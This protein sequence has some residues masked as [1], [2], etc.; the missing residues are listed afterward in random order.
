MRKETYMKQLN[1]LSDEELA[2]YM[3]SILS[4]ET[5][6]KSRDDMD[7]DTFEVLNVAIKARG[8]REA[9]LG[10]MLSMPM[11]YTASSVAY[12]AD[13]HSLPLAGFTGDN[14]AEDDDFDDDDQ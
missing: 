11:C 2:A 13:L 1:K 5:F 9:D 10:D 14:C 8:A 4:S 3:E 12:D 7:V 6:A